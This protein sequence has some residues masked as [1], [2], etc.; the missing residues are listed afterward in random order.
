MNRNS[1]LK[2]T[3]KMSISDEERKNFD[4][5]YIVV[6][7]ELL[8][9]EPQ[10]I[11]ARAKCFTDIIN[12]SCDVLISELKLPKITKN[13][14]YVSNINPLNHLN[15][16]TTWCGLRI[17]NTD[18]VP[19]TRKEYEKKSKNWLNGRRAPNYGK[20]LFPMFIFESEKYAVKLSKVLIPNN[21]KKRGLLCDI[22]VYKVLSKLCGCSVSLHEQAKKAPFFCKNSVERKCK[23]RSLL[24][25]Y[26]KEHKYVQ[27]FPSCFEEAVGYFNKKLRELIGTY[28]H[29]FNNENN[30]NNNNNNNNSKSNINNNKDTKIEI[31]MP[32]L[33]DSTTEDTI[34]EDNDIFLSNKNSGNETRDDFES[35]IEYWKKQLTIMVDRLKKEELLRIKAEKERDCLKRKLDRHQQ[36]CGLKTKT[37]SNTDR[38][39]GNISEVNKNTTKLT[40]NNNSSFS[41]L[42]NHNGMVYGNHRKLIKPDH[43]GCSKDARFSPLKGND[44]NNN[45]NNS[46]NIDGKKDNNNFDERYG[47]PKNW[48]SNDYVNDLNKTNCETN[49][50]GSGLNL[51]FVSSYNSNNDYL[52]T[53]NDGIQNMNNI[54]TLPP[55]L[56]NYTHVN[57]PS[58][59]LHNFC[60]DNDTSTTVTNHQSRRNISTNNNNNNNNHNNI[61]SI[62]NN[63]NYINLGNTI[64]H[65]SQ[66]INIYD[67]FTSGNEPRKVFNR[68]PNQMDYLDIVSRSSFNHMNEF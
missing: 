40:S 21:D 38:F 46:N 11:L 19:K 36:Q 31:P 44:Y 28:Q 12:E 27:G 35:E 16:L 52:Y 65:I 68:L 54:N 7:R 32:M 6:K 63:G 39:S 62:Q 47:I 48:V 17:E 66:P 61:T 5:W 37:E 64:S 26:A 59:A 13:L 57:I 43:Y 24:Q 2:K 22:I 51:G 20:T 23:L 60:T 1:R 9:T 45:N 50:T 25:D 33:T 55:T 15:F 67:S 29:V 56:Q 41:P 4:A 14:K 42:L 3:H 18:R 8:R 34:T 10:N 49:K 30:N 53:T 58:L